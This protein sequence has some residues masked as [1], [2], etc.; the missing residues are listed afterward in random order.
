MGAQTGL[1]FSLS[2]LWTVR[3][4]FAGEPCRGFK[5][6]ENGRTFFRYR[7]LYAT[8]TCNPGFRIHGHHTS[9]CVSG[10]WVREPPVCVA[11]GCPGP[12]EVQHGSSAVSEDRS[13]V[14][15]S[16][17]DGFRLYGSS[18]LYC[19]GKTWSDAKPVCKE[20]DI[21]SS[22]KR[23]PVVLSSS[24][25]EKSLRAPSN[26]KDHFKS[27][28]NTASKD[29]YLQPGLLVA[30]FPKSHLSGGLLVKPK[31]AP[32]QRKPVKKHWLQ[33]AAAHSELAPEVHENL[34]ATEKLARS[35]ETVT[36]VT[37]AG[38]T[39]PGSI[40][41]SSTMRPPV[42][43][44][45]DTRF[46]E[47]KM[48]GEA[49]KPVFLSDPTRADVHLENRSKEKD[50]SSPTE[51]VI[52]GPP[53]SHTVGYPFEGS[54]T[55]QQT[56]VSD[57]FLNTRTT[58]ILGTSIPHLNLNV[59]SVTSTSAYLESTMDEQNEYP[60]NR[61]VYPYSQ[62]RITGGV[63]KKAISVQSTTDH[64]HML[65]RQQTLPENKQ[66]P[67]S[68]GDQP[69]V[70]L[71]AENSTESTEHEDPKELWETPVETEKSYK[72]NEGV[73]QVAVTSAESQ[74]SLLH[75]ASA[76]VTPSVPPTAPGPTPGLPPSS[77]QPAPSGSSTTQPVRSVLTDPDDEGLRVRGLSPAEAR[78]DFQPLVE[79]AQ[80]RATHLERVQRV[81]EAADVTHAS[82]LRLA[83]QQPHMQ[84]TTPSANVLI[85]QATHADSPERSM[86][87]P[88]SFGPKHGHEESHLPT[89]DP[90]TVTPLD[91][92]RRLQ[93]LPTRSDD[94]QTNVTYSLA[95][96]ST[97]ETPSFTPSPS[98]KARPS[99]LPIRKRRPVC[100]YPP[101]PAHGTFYFRTIEKPAPLQYKHYIQY[102]CYPGYTLANG[103]VYSYC[104]Q[105]GTWSG[106]TPACLEVTPCS[107]NN[108]G[109]SQVCSAGPPGPHHRA[110]CQCKQGFMLLED[111]R[112]CRDIDECVEERHRCVQACVNT[113][114]SFRC[115]CR[116]GFQLNTDGKTCMVLNS[117]GSV[118]GKQIGS[119]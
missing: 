83:H 2:L 15:F 72:G 40:S 18:L 71:I 26:L 31:M 41:A 50:L 108:G 80:A 19:K 37:T 10:Q 68:L 11:S 107:L 65:D 119:D 4:G 86:E 7:G 67:L 112:T 94:S 84:S 28:Y 79:A 13:F 20:S 102:A 75:P 63:N 49:P 33:K 16:C 114:G 6:L 21:M 97:G 36:T 85:A 44:T 70:L 64:P 117:L 89:Q 60:K 73:T 74:A 5:H 57:Q 54:R 17:D 32:L 111:L 25:K 42:L 87:A 77:S 58:V 93:T 46:T 115:S 12:G 109:C 45:T 53:E 34:E 52:K 81:T 8:F 100:P 103:D 106:I 98:T 9:S 23:K 56:E 105:N 116:T 35:Q 27:H 3:S 62:D 95:F 22:F 61:P 1:L 90:I 24:H 38:V 30:S 29:A 91:L 118:N 88:S 78:W 104:Q 76:G 48:D 101:L 96:P 66:T 39:T 43:T 59:M 92:L 69:P 51:S 82:P 47:Y 110:Q 99:E 14:V 113:L 55:S